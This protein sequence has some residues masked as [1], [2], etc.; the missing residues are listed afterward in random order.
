MDQPA[1]DRFALQQRFGDRIGFVL[2]SSAADGL[3]QP[4]PAADLADLAVSAL[5]GETGG[6][7]EGPACGGE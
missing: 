2:I 7:L 3:R 5:A 4:V 6:I 1:V